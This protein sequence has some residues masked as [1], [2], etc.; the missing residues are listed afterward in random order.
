MAIGDDAGKAHIYFGNG[1][2]GFSETL[3]AP[4]G[5]NSSGAAVTD[6]HL[7]DVTGDGLPDIVAVSNG[8]SSSVAVF[9]GGGTSLNF[10]AKSGSPYAVSGAHRVA[11]G[12]FQASNYQGLA[13]ARNDGFLSVFTQGSTTFSLAGSPYD[14]AGN[15]SAVA[16]GD[17]DGDGTVD[18]VTADVSAGGIYV[19]KNL[20]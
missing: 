9:V 19:L 18:V 2:G 4:L 13:V 15:L 20:P 1:L 5:V 6:I 17:V 8:G 10:N 7:S 14:V 16:T 11:I 3:A 12:D